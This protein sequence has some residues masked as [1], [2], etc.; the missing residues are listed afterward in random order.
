MRKTVKK[1][2]QPVSVEERP[3]KAAAAKFAFDEDNRYYRALMAL[4]NQV[5]SKVRDLSSASLTSSKQAGEELADVA[6][7]D[8][9]RETELT[10]LSE[11]GQRLAAIQSALERLRDGSYGI[12]MDC[13]GKIQPARLTAQPDTCLWVRCKEAREAKGDQSPAWRR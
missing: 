4:R 13:A 8:F 9:I 1:R 3:A 12:C 5:V 6:S 2:T 10:L 7:D 11:E